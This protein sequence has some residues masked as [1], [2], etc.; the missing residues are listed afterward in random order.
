MLHDAE[1]LAHEALEAGTPD[2]VVDKLLA[3]KHGE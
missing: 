3:G 2:E 1:A